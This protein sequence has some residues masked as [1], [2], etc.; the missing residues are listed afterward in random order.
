MLLL[1]AILLLV[2]VALCGFA[3]SAAKPE[4]TCQD[5][6]FNRQA[7]AAVPR[8]GARYWPTPWLPGA[9]LQIAWRFL[10]DAL[11]PPLQYCRSEV[12]TM[13][14]GG[15]TAL[16]WL[17]SAL[18]DDTPILLALPTITGTAQSMRDFVQDLQRQT[19]WRVV[20]CER[21][22]HGGLPLTRPRVNT[23]GCTSDLREQIAAVQARHPAAP[24]YA[25]GLSAGSAL[26]VRYL[27]E[28][29]ADTPIRAAVAFYP[30]YDIEVACARSRPFY[31]RHMASR[32]IEHFVTPHA[33]QFGE[34]PSYAACAEA[35]DLQGFHDNLYS[36]AGY[37]SRE[38]YHAASNPVRV[39]AQIE[40]PLLVLNAADDPVCVLQNV[41][42]HEGTFRQLPRAILAVTRHGSHCAHFSGWTAGRW[43][44]A[45]AAEYLQAM[46]RRP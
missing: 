39:I 6:A 44:H 2:L 22:G 8:L 5:N 29:G 17:G 25:A 19:G 15:T 1:A 16:H 28:Q 38:A 36:L 11:L 18:P 14:D 24:L 35:A 4:L 37:D 34:M 21:R 45:L 23:M 9:H 42:D 43:G 46:N 41:R 20:V 31:S 10:R 33:E 27:G 40:V 3:V 13:R 12:L 26:L 30:G 32:L 7:L